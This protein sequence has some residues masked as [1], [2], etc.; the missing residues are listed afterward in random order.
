MKDPSGMQGMFSACFSRSLKPDCLRG[1][2][3]SSL[4]LPEEQCCMAKERSCVGAHMIYGRASPASSLQDTSL[5]LL[6]F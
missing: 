2:W 5:V 3:P 1:L 4:L 6:L